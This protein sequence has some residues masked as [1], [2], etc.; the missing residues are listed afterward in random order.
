MDRSVAF[1]RDTLGLKP[2]YIT[3]YW[4]DFDLGNGKLGLHPKTEGATEPLG[5]YKKGWYLGLA[6][7]DV[8]ALRVKL[9]EAGATIHGD[10][11]DIPGGVVLDFAD[12]DG[13]TLEAFQEGVS[14]KDFQ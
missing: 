8:R 6:T 4:S 2:G 5:I 12:P 13:N 11:H 3:P 7:T 1:Y 9:V 10:F 14:L